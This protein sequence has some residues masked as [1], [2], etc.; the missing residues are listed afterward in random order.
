MVGDRL[1]TDIA[2]GVNAGITS[3][4]VLSGESTLADLERSD[5]KPDYV[6]GDLSG[7]TDAIR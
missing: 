3:V 7:I 6:F 2:V 4:L 1:Y 5:V